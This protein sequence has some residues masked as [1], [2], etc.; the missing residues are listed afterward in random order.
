MSVINCK[1]RIP[2]DPNLF[3]PRVDESFVCTRN[4]SFNTGLCLGDLGMCFITIKAKFVEN[5]T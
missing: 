5:I 1:N 3:P 2:Q 4:T